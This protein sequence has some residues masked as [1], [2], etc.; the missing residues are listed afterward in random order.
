MKNTRYP[1][2][3]FVRE[4]IPSQ[5]S[6]VVKNDPYNLISVSKL[7]HKQQSL[8]NLLMTE[9]KQNETIVCNYAQTPKKEKKLE[10]FYIDSR[11]AWRGEKIPKNTRKAINV[12]RS[13]VINL[14]SALFLELPTFRWL[15]TEEINAQKQYIK[16]LGETVTKKILSTGVFT[17]AAL[18][19][20]CWYPVAVAEIA[21]VPDLWWTRTVCK[22]GTKQ[23]VK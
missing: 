22:P 6:Q 18:R 20:D 15:R 7:Q 4:Q 21:V 16:H 8:T 3:N 10:I 11:T 12:R 17:L 1:Y 19:W 9:S 2:Y 5:V 23:K 13:S 14:S